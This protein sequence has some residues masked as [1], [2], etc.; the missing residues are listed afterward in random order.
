MKETN[1]RIIIE[2]P[3]EL[4]GVKTIKCCECGSEFFVRGH[5]IQDGQV[6]FRFSDGSFNCPYCNADNEKHIQ[7]ILIKEMFDNEEKK[8]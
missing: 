6:M 1:R 7:D 8:Q 5:K 4:K 3:K 2:N